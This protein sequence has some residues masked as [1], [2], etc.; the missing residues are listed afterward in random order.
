MM[1]NDNYY[2]KIEEEGGVAT[3]SKVAD[4]H[5]F[6]IEAIKRVSLRQLVRTAFESSCRRPTPERIL[7]LSK[8]FMSACD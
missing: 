7:T 8:P 5:R 3:S 6:A 2:Y 4:G 1:W